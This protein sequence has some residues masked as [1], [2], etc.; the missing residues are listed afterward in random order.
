M[1]ALWILSIMIFG[2]PWLISIGL[3]HLFYWIRNSIKSLW[4]WLKDPRPKLFPRG[5]RKKNK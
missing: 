2:I 4:D 5:W 3:E 1:K